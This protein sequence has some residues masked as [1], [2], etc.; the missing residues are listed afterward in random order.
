MKTLQPS[1]IPY[2]ANK[3]ISYTSK[4]TL[5]Q[6]TVVRKRFMLFFQTDTTG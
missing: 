3:K 1:E 5:C 6:Y 2:K 4:I